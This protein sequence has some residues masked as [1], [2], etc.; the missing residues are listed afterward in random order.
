MELLTRK[1]NRNKIENYRS[2]F[3]FIV[4]KSSVSKIMTYADYLTGKKE[5]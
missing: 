3:M 2:P 1:T 4:T 5:Q